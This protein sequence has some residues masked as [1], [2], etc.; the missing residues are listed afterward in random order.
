MLELLILSYIVASLSG[1]LVGSI[2]MILTTSRS[3]TFGLTLLHSIL[4]GNI[5]GIYI[6][7]IFNLAVPVPLIS[8]IVA[9][10]L[11]II[12]GELVE[13]GFSEDISIAFSVSIATT[14]T[15]VFGYMSS[16]LSSLAI[17]RAWA[18]IA[19]TSAISTLEDLFKIALT[20]LIVLPF[21]HLFYREFKYIAF[22]E[23]GSK[24]MGLNIR[25]YRYTFYGLAAISAAILSSTI[26]VLATHVILAVPG[27]LSLKVF[28]RF[29][30]PFTYISSIG[31]M[32]LGYYIAGL[33]KI[34]PSGGIGLVSILTFLGVVAFGRH[35]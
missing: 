12:V 24:A 27:V 16:Q 9:I 8:T 29:S 10:C 20:S 32:I 13:R 17:S 15:I 6:N 33:L 3:I 22:D 14:M 35:S 7:T 1:L 19:G 5:L 4:G 2:S 28:K 23:D 26:G 25:I 34:P 21:I 18:Y 11:S 30:I 31:I